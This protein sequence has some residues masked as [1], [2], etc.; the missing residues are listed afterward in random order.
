MRKLSFYPKLA[1]GN[2]WRN[3]STYLPYLLASVVS[4]FTLY[5]MLAINLNGALDSIRGESVVKSFT[6]I[7]SVILA[8]FCAALIFYTN[9]FL[10][11]RRK[12]ELGLY[13]ILGMEKK[14]IAVL[15]FYETLFMAGLA[16]L[17][18]LMLGL[19]LSQVIYWVLMRL[20]RFPVMPAMPPSLAAMGL[21]AAFFGIVFFAALLFNLRQVRLANPINLLAGA[22]QGERE[23]KASWL[24]TVFGL[25]CL[26]GGYFVALYFRSP[27][28]ALMSFLL[29][30]LLVIIGTYCLF[31]SGSIAL[32]KLLRRSKRFYY[33]SGHFISVSGMIYRMKQN[34]AGLATI[35]IL[36]CMVLVTV[37]GTVSLNMG[38]EDSFKVQYPR[39][40]QL[41]F[42]A[43]ADGDVVLAGAEQLAARNG[44]TLAALSDY[45]V[46]SIAVEEKDGAFVAAE[47]F[48]DLSGTSLIGLVPLEDYIRSG[49]PAET[50]A[51][52]EALVFVTGG[53]YA[54]DVLTLNGTSYK[55]R[56]LSEMGT[57]KS[58]QDNLARAITLI[59]PDMATVEAAL[60]TQN[61]A[62]PDGQENRLVR[63]INFD[64]A[65]EDENKAAFASALNTFVNEGVST[66][67]RFSFRVREDSRQDWYASNGGFLFLGIYFGI[68]FTLAAVLIIYY[69][70]MSE[71]YDDVER[72]EILQKVGM[73][74]AEVKKTIN[75]QI[76]AV[77]FLPL[78]V[79]V[80]HI[81]VAFFPISRVMVIFGVL[82][83]PLLA[84][85]TAL[86]VLA[87]ALCYLFVFRRTAKTYF[88]IV[89]RQ[90]ATS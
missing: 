32:L 16:L 22:R 75:S 85:S 49:G 73:G 4:V 7:G 63:Q 90:S 36:S 81:A 86:T 47:D 80:V 13:S 55:L 1:M 53:S 27:L 57:E 25:L 69:K 42:N 3:R 59:L 34:A 76:L 62:L 40:Y 33:Q 6:F 43:P 56:H 65:G 24:L 38:A 54:G 50:L 18:G 30:V 83:L 15:M 67:E 61:N 37:S 72:F 14:N 51:P 58:G 70:Q 46:A 23:P 2:L 52:G 12:K 20:I 68:L 45:R 71:G 74:E 11:K 79:A 5:T 41:S 35:C 82:N 48:S 77:F 87:Y 19:L 8:L 44:I 88:T 64:L 89:K 26:G 31:T 39:E 78:L 66:S 60:A 9:S 17:A 28:E 84:A 10:I 21:T 29:A